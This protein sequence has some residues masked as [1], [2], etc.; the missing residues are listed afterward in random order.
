MD[1][2]EDERT[3]CFVFG[4]GTSCKWLPESLLT[5]FEGVYMVK[6]SGWYHLGTDLDARDGQLKAEMG[7]K[8]SHYEVS[9]V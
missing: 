3:V 7:K 4:D 1:W 8:G 5:G 6:M 2:K 9:L